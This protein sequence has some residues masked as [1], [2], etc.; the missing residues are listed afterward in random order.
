MSVPTRSGI[1][2]A[3][4]IGSWKKQP[5]SVRQRFRRVWRRNEFFRQ[6]DHFHQPVAPDLFSSTPVGEPTRSKLLNELSKQNPQ[7]R[8]VALEGLVSPGSGALQMAARVKSPEFCG[9]IHL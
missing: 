4:Y 2:K 5:K 9:I 3:G 1:S 7:V 8:L 6:K